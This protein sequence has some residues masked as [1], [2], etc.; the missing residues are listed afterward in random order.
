MAN[1]RVIHTR[2]SVYEPHIC[3][4]YE[5]KTTLA[6]GSRR[7]RSICMYQH[8]FHSETTGQSNQ[9]KRPILDGAT[10]STGVVHV[11]LRTFFEAKVDIPGGLADDLGYRFKQLTR[12]IHALIVHP[13]TAP[14][15]TANA[16]PALPRTQGGSE[17]STLC[18]FF[19]ETCT[20]WSLGSPA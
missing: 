20:A 14:L 18:V 11:H 19:F 2:F 1:S 5:R 17:N 13:C 6:P 12:F 15:S 7:V 8:R 4:V 10:G 3:D 16:H 9:K